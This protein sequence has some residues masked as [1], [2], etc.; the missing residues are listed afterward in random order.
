MT[1]GNGKHSESTAPPPMTPTDPPILPAALRVPAAMSGS[2]PLTSTPTIMAVAEMTTKPRPDQS[3]E[4]ITVGSADHEMCVAMFSYTST[5]PGDLTFNQGDVITLLKTDGEWWTG[6]MDGQTGIFPCTYCKKIESTQKLSGNKKPEIASVIAPYQGTGVEQ[7]TLQPG[8]LI[9]VRKKSPSGWWEG[10]LQAKGQKR[11]IGWFPA[12][13]V[14]LLGQGSPARTSNDSSP[15]P[16]S[17]SGRV[18]AGFPVPTTVPSV[19]QVVATYNYEPR[20]EDELSF[21]RGSVI[22]V[23][24]KQDADWW[25]GEQ[26]GRVGMFPSNYVTA[27]KSVSLDQAGSASPATVS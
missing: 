8:Q 22:N 11:R 24:D 16:D 10:E 1:N 9:S 15:M 5:E 19:E 20:Q 13:Y 26:G 17:M 21:T 7:L 25:K 4:K 2:Q 6:S 12:N 3:G 27:L 23:L 14:R 18:S